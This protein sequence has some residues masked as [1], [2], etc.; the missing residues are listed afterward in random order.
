M[1]AVDEMRDKN[2]SRSGAV[3]LLVNI[4]CWLY[5]WQFI[6]CWSFSRRKPTLCL[7]KRIL[8]QSFMMN[9]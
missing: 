1:Q 7:A 3:P 4:V 9:W 6:I 2:G 5:R 8:C